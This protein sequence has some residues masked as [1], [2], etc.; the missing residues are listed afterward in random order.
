MIADMNGFEWFLLNAVPKNNMS[1]GIKYENI[2]SKHT[3][4]AKGYFLITWDNEILIR[5]EFVSKHKRPPGHTNDTP[6]SNIAFAPEDQS[7]FPDVY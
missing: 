1:C 7:P 5:W 4:V 6:F 3:I 2:P